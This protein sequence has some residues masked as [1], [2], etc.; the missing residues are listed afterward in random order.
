MSAL[1][2]TTGDIEIFCHPSAGT[3]RTT[4]TRATVPFFDAIHVGDCVAMVFTAGDGAEP[5][6]SLKI[7][8]PSGT[9][10]VDTIVRDLPT[11]LPQSPPPIDFVVSA[12]GIYRVEIRELKGRHRGEAKLRVT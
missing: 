3:T 9:N 1:I 5:P 11:G 8:S 12:R 7:F 4:V 10:I 2:E 6:F